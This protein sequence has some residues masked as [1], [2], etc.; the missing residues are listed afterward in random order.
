MSF[1]WVLEIGHW[2]DTIKSC[3]DAAIRTMADEYGSTAID[4]W[5]SW[6]GQGVFKRLWPGDLV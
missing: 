5:G 1:Y 4:C 6:V 2:S 3:R